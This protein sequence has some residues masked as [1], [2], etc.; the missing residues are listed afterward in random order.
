MIERVHAPLLDYRVRCV[1]LLY[2]VQLARADSSVECRARRLSL[3]YPPYRH[4]MA[5][6]AM[7]GALLAAVSPAFAS[8]AASPL[9]AIPPDLAKTAAPIWAA[10]DN[11]DFSMAR[12]EFSATKPIEAAVA[13][14]TAQLS[15][16][17][18]PDPRLVHNDYGASMPHG[19]TSQPK[20]FGA[21]KLY[22]NGVMVGMG[23]GRRVNQTQGVDAIDVT[24][25]IRSGG[26]NAV[27]LQGYHSMRFKNDTARMLLQLV[28]THTD[29]SSAVVSTGAKWTAIGANKVFN[30][31][32]SSGAWAGASGFPHEMI[33]M[34]EYPVGWNLPGYNGTWAQAKVQP[35]FVL[36]LG[37]KSAASA[38]PIGIFSRK[39]VHIKQYTAAPPP[40]PNPHHHNPPPPAPAG[41]PVPCGIVDEGHTVNI[42][43]AAK[44]EKVAKVNFASFGTVTG[45][46]TPDG[47][48]SFKKGS[49]D[50]SDT[51]AVLDK[52]CVGRPACEIAIGVHLFGEPCHLVHKK[53]A[54]AVTC[55][56]SGPG[57]SQPT[58]GQLN[59][60]GSHED[61]FAHSHAGIGPG[62][63][64]LI[65]FGLEMQGGV[66]ITFSNAEAGQKVRV[67]LSEELLPN[68]QIK[69]PMRTTNDFDDTWTLRD[70]PQTVM[71]HEYME[72][73]YA[74]IVRRRLEN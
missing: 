34:R 39:A 57:P 42:G 6:L 13:F 59:A 26:S 32:G 46:C 22:I 68:G 51:L 41:P 1:R 31:T 24:S 37:P 52:A 48:Y 44:G 25:V 40:P 16:Y 21:Y 43:C 74:E 36:P 55:A 67:K 66:N 12:T 18:Q 47:N 53:L 20:L 23:P 56:A 72:F 17:A 62:T 27:G 2:G 7:L 9:L 4:A 64:Y 30:P 5:V 10:G 69:V 65:D 49:C 45:A 3:R 63:A 8:A 14:V 33:D 28:L 58:R 60:T 71:Q 11:S 61:V 29:G 19:G 54:W 35:P 38:R 50:A 15:P 70:G 73:R